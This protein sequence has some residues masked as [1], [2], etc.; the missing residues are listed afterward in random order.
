MSNSSDPKKVYLANFLNETECNNAWILNGSTITLS[1]EPIFHQN[2]SFGGLKHI[3]KSYERLE[4]NENSDGD[5][6]NQVLIPS[7]EK[8]Q[9]EITIAP[10]LY[11][12]FYFY[13][14]LSNVI[15]TGNTNTLKDPS[16]MI[17]KGSIAAVVTVAI[18]CNL[19]NKFTKT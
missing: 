18:F 11:L 13:G 16:R 9:P 12:L 3:K 6:T 14:S 8:I 17:P 15:S 10:F 2:I 7:K 5:L 19:N 4:R 1:Y